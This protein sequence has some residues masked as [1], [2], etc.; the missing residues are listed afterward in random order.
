M[1][2]V[3]K[4]KYNET[5]IGQKKNKL[6]VI[7]ITW[8]KT[9]GKKRFRCCC[10]CG[11]VKDIKPTFWDNGKIKSCGCYFESLKVEHT[12]EV[13]RLKRIYRGM[14]GRCYDKKHKAYKYYGLRGITICDEWRNDPDEFIRWALSHGYSG[15]L[16]ID[17]IDND[18]NYEPGNCRWAD[19][20]TQR[21]NQRTRY[22]AKIF[23]VGGEL[24]SVND[25]NERLPI[26][27]RTLMREVEEGKYIVGAFTAARKVWKEKHGKTYGRKEG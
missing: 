7:G 21:I 10:D 17:R 25:I 6:T 15:D 3:I 5:Y 20:H 23:N 27:K 26:D 18:G 14:I 1:S 24:L 9:T 22:T 16:T 13:D 12:P 11:N 8:D 4:G 2:A 19:K